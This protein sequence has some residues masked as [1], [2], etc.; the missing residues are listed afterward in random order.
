V[1]WSSSSLPSRDRRTRSRSSSPA[2]LELANAEPGTSVWFALR[3]DNV[4]RSSR[5][6]SPPDRRRCGPQRVYTAQQR[7]AY[8]DYLASRPV[9]HTLTDL[10]A[11]FA[12]FM[13]LQAQPAV[14]RPTD[15]DVAQPGP[16]RARNWR[17]PSR[18][19]CPRCLSRVHVRQAHGTAACSAHVLPCPQA[20]LGQAKRGRAQPE[21]PGGVNAS[22]STSPCRA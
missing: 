14:Q 22:Q 12:T 7:Q 2:A 20:P 19:H 3:T 6:K 13:P 1:L 16:P 17:S 9:R 10:S 21:L 5:R 4:R 18:S 11:L 15:T 8:D